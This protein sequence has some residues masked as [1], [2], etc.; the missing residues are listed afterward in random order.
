[1]R[2][3][4]CLVAKSVLVASLSLLVHV[5]HAAA[6]SLCPHEYP[7]EK[8]AC[9]AQNGYRVG[10]CKADCVKAAL[11]TGK[12][13]SILHSRPHPTITIALVLSE[14]VCSRIVEDRF[15]RALVSH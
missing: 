10:Y 6:S 9:D 1:M 12:N 15:P 2:K 8:K 14:E 4:Y 7:E 3:V 11:D 5:A 13:A